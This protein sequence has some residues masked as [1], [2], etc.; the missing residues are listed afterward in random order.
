MAL[1]VPAPAERQCRPYPFAI[2]MAT[3]GVGDHLAGEKEAQ[4]QRRG[5]CTGMAKQ[6]G[7][8]SSSPCRWWRSYYSRIETFRAEGK[9]HAR[10]TQTEE[11]GR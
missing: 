5:R 2:A 3:A 11:K 1:D 8:S 9:D 4:Q 6:F 10:K 7:V